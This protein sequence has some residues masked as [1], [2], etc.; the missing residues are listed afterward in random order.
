MSRSISDSRYRRIPTPIDTGRAARPNQARLSAQSRRVEVG[1]DELNDTA[2]MALTMVTTAPLASHLTCWR[3]HHR[4]HAGTTGR[5]PDAEE[6]FISRGS[7]AGATVG[8]P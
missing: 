8:N 7:G 5:I 2:M 1:P 3:R 6:R 4:P